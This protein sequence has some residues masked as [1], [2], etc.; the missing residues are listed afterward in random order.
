MP[1]EI[2]TLLEMASKGVAEPSHG[3]VEK[4][5][6]YQR[7][8]TKVMDCCKKTQCGRVWGRAAQSRTTVSVTLGP[9]APCQDYTICSP[10][11]MA[12]P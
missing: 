12:H 7:K 1:E 4:C 10:G 3:E 6:D 11:L 2:V 9:W 8:K 5:L